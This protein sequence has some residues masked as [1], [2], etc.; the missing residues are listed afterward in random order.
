MIGYI[1]N[2]AFSRLYASVHESL[3]RNINNSYEI[4]VERDNSVDFN[5]PYIT[6]IVRINNEHNSMEYSF[7]DL[8]NKIGFC[9]SNEPNLRQIM[10]LIDDEAYDVNV[11]CIDHD[12]DNKVTRII[13]SNDELTFKL[14]LISK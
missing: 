3:V 14:H 8:T 13:L 7:F 5:M 10:I 2:E 12:K 9:Q 1:L 4:I 11:D 6:S